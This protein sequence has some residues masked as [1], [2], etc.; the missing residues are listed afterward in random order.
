[1]HLDII[2]YS[3][4]KQQYVQHMLACYLHN[5][6]LNYYT[7]VNIFNVSSSSLNLD[8]EVEEEVVVQVVSAFDVAG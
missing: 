2:G 3:I 8:S 7:N 6:K 1:M 4:V 5:I